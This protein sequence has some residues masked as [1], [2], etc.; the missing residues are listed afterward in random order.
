MHQI[1]ISA[2]QAVEICGKIEA[3]RPTYTRFAE[4]G[5]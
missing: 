3:L 1:P 4:A 2:K 5:F